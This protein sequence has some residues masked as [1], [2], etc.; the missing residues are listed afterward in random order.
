MA[1]TKT[2]ETGQT[3]IVGQYKHIQVRTDTIIKED[4]KELSRTYHR[5]THMCGLIDDE[6][7]WH[8]TDLSGESSEIQ[9]IANIVWTQSVKDAW[10]AKL[11]ADK[12]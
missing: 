11:I 1:I 8:D 5:T 6:D 2:T 7:K 10:K 4:G 12:D 3:E 9:S